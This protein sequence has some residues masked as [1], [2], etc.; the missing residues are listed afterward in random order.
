MARLCSIFVAKA[1]LYRLP[2]GYCSGIG[3][4]IR[5]NITINLTETWTI[6]W[7]TADEPQDQADKIA[8]DQ[9]R[10]QEES[11]EVILTT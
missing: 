10:T 7:T 4:I 8:L 9:P 3:K 6:V 1:L 5:P 2:I 11:H